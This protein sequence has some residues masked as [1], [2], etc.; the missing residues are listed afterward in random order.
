MTYIY[1]GYPSTASQSLGSLGRE[2]MVLH[3]HA[4]NREETQK[5]KHRGKNNQTETKFISQT[6]F[7]LYQN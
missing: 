5:N 4:A 3:S 1:D 2:A 6:S 7:C